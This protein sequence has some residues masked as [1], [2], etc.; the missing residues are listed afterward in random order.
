[1]RGNEIFRNNESEGENEGEIFFQN[2]NPTEK[3]V[4]NNQMRSRNVKNQIY[5]STREK[6]NFSPKNYKNTSEQPESI[7]RSHNINLFKQQR[8]KNADKTLTDQ[9]ISKF[10][11]KLENEITLQKM[12]EYELQL[13]KNT[14]TKS[15]N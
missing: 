5:S 7:Y 12:R 14:E 1:M 6:N 15:I 10:T 3:N 13:Q 8:Y 4:V 11:G 9:F 2:N